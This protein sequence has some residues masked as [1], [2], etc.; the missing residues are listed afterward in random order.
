MCVVQCITW[1][2][3]HKLL[4]NVDQYSRSDLIL[5]HPLLTNS[6][7][8]VVRVEA[9]LLSAFSTVQR[10]NRQLSPPALQ[11]CACSRGAGGSKLRSI[12]TRHGRETR[13]GRGEL[14]KG[15]FV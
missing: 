11:D 2:K 10:L 3:E 14:Q 12:R 15:A 7:K 5:Q 8:C 13:E 6:S 4:Y 9:V 1:Q